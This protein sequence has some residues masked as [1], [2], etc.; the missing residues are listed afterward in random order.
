LFDLLYLILFLLFL[1][2]IEEVIVFLN[3]VSL[4]VDL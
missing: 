1:S 2:K 4:E 3:F